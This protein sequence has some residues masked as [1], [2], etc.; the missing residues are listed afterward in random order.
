[1]KLDT[2]EI[3]K[4]ILNRSRPNIEG[5][6]LIAG[7]NLN[8][9]V[10]HMS[11]LNESHDIAINNIRQ[12]IDKSTNFEEK[13]KLYYELLGKQIIQKEIDAIIQL[14]KQH[15][16][17]VFDSTNPQQKLKELLLPFQDEIA[18]E[19]VRLNNMYHDLIVNLQN[20]AQSIAA[21]K[22]DPNQ[23]PI[24]S[25][26][27]HNL[28]YKY[29]QFKDIYEIIDKFYK[30]SY[31]KQI[32]FAQKCKSL[33]Q[34]HDKNVNQNDTHDN[35]NDIQF[36]QEQQLELSKQKKVLQRKLE[37]L[38]AGNKQEDYYKKESLLNELKLLNKT[39]GLLQTT[40]NIISSNQTSEEYYKQM[41]EGQQ[42]TKSS[43]ITMINK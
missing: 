17:E 19:I 24:S 31:Q 6:F 25:A 22:I 7:D 26:V 32:D 18:G 13:S 33:I 28:R 16:D 12:S 30:Q 42:S 37:P 15:G 38:L 3:Q 5:L 35:S 34:I 20:N 14:A 2:F 39:L 10:D 43:Q 9:F 21:M 1:M 8:Q 29:E 4:K 40:S 41:K 23:K 36:L 27:L 11:K